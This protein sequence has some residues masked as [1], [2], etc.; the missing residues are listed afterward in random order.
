MDEAFIAGCLMGGLVGLVLG[1]VLAL[2]WMHWAF[3]G[4]L[5]PPP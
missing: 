3:F 1:I 2:W 4:E 5:P